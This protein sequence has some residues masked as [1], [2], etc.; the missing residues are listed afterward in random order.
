MISKSFDSIGEEA[1]EE[2]TEPLS[3]NRTKQDASQSLWSQS[4]HQQLSTTVSKEGQNGIPEHT[5]GSSTSGSQPRPMRQGGGTRK[6]SIESPTASKT[7]PIPL[8]LEAM[9]LEGPPIKTKEI[10][11]R[12]LTLGSKEAALKTSTHKRLV[13]TVFKWMVPSFMFEPKSVWISGSFN[14]WEKVL[15]HGSK[16]HWVI[17]IDLPQ[18][19]HQYKFKV[20]DKWFHNQKEP[21]MPDGMGGL[22]N[23]I[24]VRK[25]D[26]EVFE[27][28]DMDCRD[29]N[30]KKQSTESEEFGQVVPNFSHEVMMSG[31]RSNP[32]ILP[33]QLLQVMLNK[34]TPLS[35]EPTLLPLPN[36]V[37]LNHMYALSIRDKVMVM[38]TT[39]R[40]RKKYVTTVLYRPVN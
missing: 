31:R 10:R 27:A 7:A 8:M 20:D 23:V 25:S 14:N 22:N 37:M 34:D 19:E 15:M 4:P 35:C 1:K 2:E 32:P 17:I 21:T 29:V 33:P 30:A 12:A 5:N 16:T 18:G 3:M 38:S 24:V 39:Q 26:F 11:K 28:L 6:G 9:S 13:P 36:H 40:F